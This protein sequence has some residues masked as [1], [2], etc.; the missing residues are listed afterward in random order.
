[1]PEL[2]RAVMEL[3]VEAYNDLDD[4]SPTATRHEVTMHWQFMTDCIKLTEWRL[5]DAQGDWNRF[6]VVVTHSCDAAR[7]ITIW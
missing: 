3:K 5:R 1:V 4:A 6:C 7:A 2:D